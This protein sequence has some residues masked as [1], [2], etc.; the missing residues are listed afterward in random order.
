MINRPTE[1]ILNILTHPLT[2][3]DAQ[4]NG[5]ETERDA[6]HNIQD[7]AEHL[8]GS[9]HAIRFKHVS[10]EG[11]VGPNKADGYA[12]PDIIGYLEPRLRPGEE[13]AEKERSADIDHESA[14]REKQ[15]VAAQQ[16]RHAVTAQAAQKAEESDAETH[17]K[18]F[19]HSKSPSI[20]DDNK[21]TS[22][23]QT[24][25]VIRNPGRSMSARS[26]YS[27]FN[28]DGSGE[29]HHPL[30]YH[31][32]LFEPEQMSIASAMT[33]YLTRPVTRRQ[34]DGIAREAGD[35]AHRYLCFQDW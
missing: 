35:R 32:I 18:C 15:A 8:A 5:D 29:L 17:N 21:K 14:P 19:L 26:H 11:G 6:S 12:D 2:E 3:N 7:T 9:E 31:L 30:W 16:S 22:A 33:S 24:A 10:G 13:P 1:T 25:E 27:R 28:R 23:V 20:S 4:P 34:T